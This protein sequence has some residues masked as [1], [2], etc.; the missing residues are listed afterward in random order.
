[1]TT[2]HTGRLILRPLVE[3][4]AEAYAAMRYH[5]DVARWL[6]GASGDPR[7]AARTT[8][9]Y[10]AGL[11]QTDGYAPWGMFL[12]ESDGSEGRLIGQGGLRIIPEFEA[13]EVLYAMHPDAW[14]KGYAT[15]MG[16]AA[17]DFGFTDKGLP[18][19]FAITKPDNLASQAVMKRLGMQYRRNVVYKTVDAVWLD[20]DAATW[21][22]RRAA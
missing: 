7:D 1:M 3:T 16:E 20:I 6:I 8:I 14:G 22:A 2:L 9:A 12:R 18:L 5:P 17:L 11:W 10:F 13:T 21:A 19:I 4:D 15:E